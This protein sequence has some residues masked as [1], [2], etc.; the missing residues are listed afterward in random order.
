MP[1][2]F[3]RADDETV[4]AD[5]LFGGGVPHDQ[6]VVAVLGQIFGVDVQLLA[7]AATRAAERDFAQAGELAPPRPTLRNRKNA[8]I[9]I[10]APVICNRDRWKP[11]YLPLKGNSSAPN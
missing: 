6:L 10:F 8:K 7:R 2:I 4:A 5:D 1:R 11:S 3:I 9:G